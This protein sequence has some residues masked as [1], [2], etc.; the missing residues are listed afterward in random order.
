S[1]GMP[2]L[3]RRGNR[4][5]WA[6]CYAQLR[7]SMAPPPPARRASGEE[8]MELSRSRRRHAVA[9]VAAG[10]LAWL[11]TGCVT[12]VSGNPQ[13][14]FNPHSDYANDGL[15]LFVLTIILGVIIGVIVE[16]V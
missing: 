15:N 1:G 3:R 4:A 10:V 12:N 2:A 14:A 7:F 8:C 13:T 11:A 9:I 5:V 16:I 6:S